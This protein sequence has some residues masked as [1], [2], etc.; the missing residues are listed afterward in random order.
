MPN[1]L[2]R[3]IALSVGMK[4]QDVDVFAKKLDKNFLKFLKKHSPEGVADR[5]GGGVAMCRGKGTEEADEEG[6]DGEETK[7]GDGGEATKEGN[8]EEETKERVEKDL[9][10]EGDIDTCKH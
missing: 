3:A 5:S 8:E 6:D 2:I 4:K 1:L 7:E 10:L 9:D